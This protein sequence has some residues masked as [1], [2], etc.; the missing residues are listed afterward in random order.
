MKAARPASADA[1]DLRHDGTTAAPAVSVVIPMYNCEAFAS[2]L[3][4]MFSRQ[5][6]ADFEAI[7][8]IDG[9][10][11]RTEDI[12][13]AHCERDSRFRYVLRENGGAGAARNTGLDYVRSEY[14]V[15]PDA[16]DEYSPEYLRGLYETAREAEADIAICRYEVVDHRSGGRSNRGFSRTRLVEGKVYSHLDVENLGVAAPYRITNQLY[17]ADFLREHGLLYSETAVANDVFFNYAAVFCA[18]RIAVTNECLM[19]VHRFV[20]PESISGNR[21]F[22]LEDIVFEYR[23]LYGWLEAHGL[24]EAHLDDYLRRF[25]GDLAYAL[26]F[27]MNAK[28]LKAMA[29]SLNAEEPFASMDSEHLLEYFRGSLLQEYA[30]AQLGDLGTA[31]D[32]VAPDTDPWLAILVERWRNRVANAEILRRICLEKY[33]RDLSDPRSLPCRPKERREQDV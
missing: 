32:I 18:E 7:C 22:H 10:T 13:A 21:R 9:A 33:G 2:D 5:T 24:L 19:T 27:P 23:K 1:L 11:D 26:S 29:A 17:R 25:N 8:V 14:V 4:E 15:W 28:F 31:R 20:N 3:L 12:V 6:F 16:D 30:A